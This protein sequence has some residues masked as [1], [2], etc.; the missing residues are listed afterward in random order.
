MSDGLVEIGKEGLQTDCEE[1]QY[2]HC[3]RMLHLLLLRQCVGHD[4]VSDSAMKRHHEFS[5][6]SMRQNL[7]LI[8]GD[9]TADKPPERA[10]HPTAEQRF[11]IKIS[12]E[13]MAAKL[14]DTVVRAAAH[15]TARIFCAKPL[16]E[17][18][19]FIGHVRSKFLDKLQSATWN[20]NKAI[21]KNGKRHNRRALTMSSRKMRL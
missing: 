6:F 10:G 21:K 17:I 1:W 20:K 7:P 12:K 8:N 11:P 4:G 14:F 2:T 9:N 16:N 13:R 15:A 3:T 18:P 19:S 5:K